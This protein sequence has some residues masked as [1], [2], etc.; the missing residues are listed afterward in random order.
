VGRLDTGDLNRCSESVIAGV[1]ILLGVVVF[2]C[3]LSWVVSA[4]HTHTHTLH[5]AT[6]SQAK[7]S[8]LRE[9]AFVEEGTMLRPR[10]SGMITLLC[11]V[12]LCCGVW[13]HTSHAFVFELRAH[14]E[15]CFYEHTTV[16]S[17]IGL[18]FQVTMGGFLDIDV[19]VRAAL[20]GFFAH[21]TPM[22]IASCFVRH[23]LYFFLP[24][25]DRV[26]LL[27]D[28]LLLSLHCLHLLRIYPLLCCV[29]CL[30][31]FFSPLR[32]HSSASL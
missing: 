5:G 26:L 17:P 15:T 30:L 3:S 4:T 32:I 1:H 9:T 10:R 25:F 6:V 11:A 18:R 2:G 13:A 31:V 20:S 27:P 21:H 14:Q 7:P 22:C 24:C 19:K 16:D 12:V 29:L 8:P 23:S 28:F